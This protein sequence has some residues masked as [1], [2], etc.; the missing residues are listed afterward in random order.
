MTNAMKFVK[1]NFG[2]DASVRAVNPHY[3]GEQ[4]EVVIEDGNGKYLGRGSHPLL[5]EADKELNGSYY[6]DVFRAEC[7]RIEALDQKEAVRV[8]NYIANQLTRDFYQR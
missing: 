3:W 8:N 2:P 1:K 4:N 7:E 5:W 6:E